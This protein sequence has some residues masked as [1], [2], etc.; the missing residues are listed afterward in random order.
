M[1]PQV[2][3]PLVEFRSSDGPVITGLGVPYYDG[4]PN[5][6]LRVKIDDEL[7][8]VERVMPGAFNSSLRSHKIDEV[9][10]YNHG[11]GVLANGF[12]L[13][14]RS[15]GTL[16]LRE[17]DA[18]VHYRVKPPKGDKT[19]DLL[20]LIQRRDVNGSSIRMDVQDEE[21]RQED[22]TIIREVKSATLEEVGPVDEAAYAVTTAEVR[23]RVKKL[24]RT[25]L[26]GAEELLI[27]EINRRALLARLSSAT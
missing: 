10:Y 16:L 21:Y 17:D 7:W 25:L 18:G 5:T 11:P 23:S 22:D 8:A 13:G 14:R 27:R 1:L 24:D 12:L 2:S 6:E 20:E 26:P 4:T 19:D 3:A 15:S 9:S